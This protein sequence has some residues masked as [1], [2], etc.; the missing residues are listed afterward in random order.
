MK[1]IKDKKGSL[2]VE[3]NKFNFVVYV[4]NIHFEGFALK[5][6]VGDSWYYQ[7]LML[8]VRGGAK[9]YFKPAKN[10]YNYIKKQKLTN[11]TFRR[12]AV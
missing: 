6:K 10:L 1:V 3:V 11:Q 9:N 7:H 2:Q 5:Y 4:K 8:G 12:L